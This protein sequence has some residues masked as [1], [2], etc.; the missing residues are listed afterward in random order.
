MAQA[1]RDRQRW[2]P[3]KPTWELLW[4]P[5]T[6]VVFLGGALYARRH[7][8]LPQG[9]PWETSILWAICGTLWSLF[10]AGVKALRRRLRRR[11][12]DGPAAA[13]SVR[14]QARAVSWALWFTIYMV[15]AH[16]QPLL[17]GL[18]LPEV[19]VAAGMAI[20]LIE[21]A[22]LALWRRGEAARRRREIDD[23]AQRF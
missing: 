10:I 3:P 2:E 1:V 23:L 8:F 7:H 14:E 18:S 12:A 5:A 20:V 11:K 13:G 6:F 22:L 15:A 21:I 4:L 9:N 19:F 16:L 17:P